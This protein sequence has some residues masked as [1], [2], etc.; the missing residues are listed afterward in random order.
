VLAADFFFQHAPNFRKSSQRVISPGSLFCHDCH[1]TAPVLR[2]LPV[3]FYTPSRADSPPT[4]SFTES[5]QTN[6]RSAQILDSLLNGGELSSQ[7]TDLLPACSSPSLHISSP[8]HF[9]PYCHPSPQP[10]TSPHL[11]CPTKP[12]DDEFLPLCHRHGDSPSFLPLHLD[13]SSKVHASM[14]HHCV[15]TQSLH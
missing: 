1:S 2:P 6:A 7:C 14:F 4:D 3:R 11:H 5:S 13:P 9:Y 12:Q 15:A 8:L 10:N